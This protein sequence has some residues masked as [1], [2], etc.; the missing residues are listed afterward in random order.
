MK[1]GGTG[2]RAPNQAD[3]YRKPKPEPQAPEQHVHTC[4]FFAS[5]GKAQ[6]SH[7][8]TL[9]PLAKSYGGCQRQW[10]GNGGHR[11]P[12]THFTPTGINYKA[13]KEDTMGR[14]WVRGSWDRFNHV[15]KPPSALAP[16]QSY[17]CRLQMQRRHAIAFLG[18]VTSNV[19]MPIT[20]KSSKAR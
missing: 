18:D 3:I 9:N 15:G 17:M 14:P 16:K 13:L 10:T 12:A 8:S 20:P 6:T 11:L 5:Q 7:R 19:N 2:T 4:M 1:D